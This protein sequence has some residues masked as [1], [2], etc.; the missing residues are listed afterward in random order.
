VAMYRELFPKQR[1]VVD[2]V[3]QMKRQLRGSSIG[4][5]T[6]DFLPLLDAASRSLQ[7]LE[8]G[9][10]EEPAIK[11]LRYDT[12]RG[13]IAIDLQTGN[14]DQ[15]EAYRDLLTAEGLEVDILSANQDGDIIKGRIQVGRS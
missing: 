13:H 3:R 7:S 5:T 10:G 1:K 9:E 15:L 12:Q 11:Q 6:S 2:P 14:I 4:A 8:T